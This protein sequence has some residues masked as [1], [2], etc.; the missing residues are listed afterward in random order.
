MAGNKPFLRRG[1]ESAVSG[2]GGGFHGVATCV[3][4]GCHLVRSE[5]SSDNV[6]TKTTFYWPG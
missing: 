2:G 4:W 5:F 3:S 6:R 1:R